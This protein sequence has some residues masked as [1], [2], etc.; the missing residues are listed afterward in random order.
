MPRN[1]RKSWKNNNRAWHVANTFFVLCTPLVTLA[2]LTRVLTPAGVGQ[3]SYA[4]SVITYFTV[5]AALGFGYY[6]RREMVKER[7]NAYNRSCLFW[8][9]FLCRLIPTLIALCINVVLSLMGAYGDKSFLMLVMS[10]NIVAVAI[11]TG[12]LFRDLDCYKKLVIRGIAVKLVTVILTFLLVRSESDVWKYELIHYGAVIAGNIVM[13]AGVPGL[14]VKVRIS[15]LRPMRHLPETLRLFVP[16]IVLNVYTMLDKT[17]IG[18]ITHSDVEN[19]YYEMAD[20]V[21][22]TVLTSVIAGIALK[23]AAIER[24]IRNGHTEQLKEEIYSCA[25]FVWLTGGA[26][27]GLLP[28][29]ACNLGQTYFGGDYTEVWR[30][31]SVLAFLPLIIGM[32][33]VIGA[34]YLISTGQDKKFTAS[35]L[36]G[37]VLNISLNIPFIIFFGAF[38]AAVATIIAECAVIALQLFF[39]RKQLSAA[40]IL[41]RG[42]KNVLAGGA[43]FAAAFT[44]SRV[45]PVSVGYGALALLAGCAAYLFSLAALG[46]KYFLGG[47]KRLFSAVFGR[48]NRKR[49]CERTAEDIRVDEEGAVYTEHD[50][51]HIGDELAGDNAHYSD[52]ATAEHSCEYEQS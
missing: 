46:S 17:L 29:V 24:E 37:A 13:W 39:V 20:V 1:L 44:L 52:D 3:Y 30:I 35:V 36:T 51:T 18:A 23:R 19:G 15:D 41:I 11:D 26:A 4:G 2:Y 43:A 28:A 12:F 42:I 14:I 45:L 22:R 32:S 50:E 40:E 34:N 25:S 9:I 5:F 49:K 38:G 21:I 7:D 10:C 31:L 48:K 27:A 6:A 8:D 16:T 47:A 33:S